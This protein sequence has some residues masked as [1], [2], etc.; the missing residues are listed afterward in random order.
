MSIT[1]KDVES[2]IIKHMA[3]R[4]NNTLKEI[5]LPA[6]DTPAVGF[7]SAADALYPFYKKHIGEDFY[8]LPTEWLKSKYGKDFDPE[9]VSVISWVVP[10]TENTRKLAR[11]KDDCPTMEWEM[12]RVHGEECN[13]A[14][15]DA[16][17]AWLGEQ[18]YEAIAPMTSPEFSW[19][20]SERFYLAS[21]WSE[22][23]TAFISGLGTF[24]LCDG[25]ISVKGKAVRYGSVIV[26][27]KLEPTKRNYTEYN[28][29]CQAKNGC[30]AC[31]ERCP[32][33]AITLE[34]G[35]DKAKCQQYHKEFIAPIC[36]ERYGYDGYST[37]GLCQT[38]VPCEAGIP[39]SLK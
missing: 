1:N 30:R 36:H 24:G 16:V 7:S 37:C 29:Y 17:V 15:A 35:H 21:N 2:F 27:A 10:Q 19:Q 9:N 11:E 5:D 22:R 23:H 39:K 34:G 26:N 18:G 28:E 3:Q 20:D 14:L 38:G 32:A 13:R 6:F 8:R 25:L 33:G 4:E 12:A 31:I